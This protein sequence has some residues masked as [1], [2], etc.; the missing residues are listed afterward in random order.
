MLMILPMFIACGRQYKWLDK[1][2]VDF[3]GLAL[4]SVLEEIVG[5][6]AWSR[7]PQKTQGG[8]LHS[9]KNVN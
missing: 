8:R 3:T 1:I 2:R 4:K 7:G 5:R 6:S 9:T